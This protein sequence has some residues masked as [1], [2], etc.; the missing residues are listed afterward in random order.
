MSIDEIE[1][2]LIGGDNFRNY[3]K[4][5]EAVLDSV[6]LYCIRTKE[7][8]MPLIEAYQVVLDGRKS[9]LLYIGIAIGQT[10]RERLKQEIKHKKPGTFFRAMGC[11]L[12]YKA[13]IGC[14]RGCRNKNNFKFSE[15]DTREIT[16]WLIENAEI[17]IINLEPSLIKRAEKEL[18]QRR[19]PLLNWQHNPTKL[20]GL[21]DVDRRKCRDLAKQCN[22]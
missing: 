4:L 18:I 15:S 16:K 7:R 3:C 20:K 5:P 10:L 22:Q 19:N 21:L 12:G 14:C 17:S 11:A 2:Q 8:A 1:K 13:E 6:G 9:K